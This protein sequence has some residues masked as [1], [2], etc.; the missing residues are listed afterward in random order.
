MKK[1]IYFVTLLFSS[2]TFAT[3]SPY[4]GEITAEDLLAQYPAFAKEYKNYSP[5]EDDLNTIKTLSGK[6]VLVFLGTWCHDSKR[7][8]PRLLKLLDGSG[9]KLGSLQLIAVGYDKL[10]PDGLAKQYDLRYTPTFIVSSNG[11]ELL[12]MIEK[13]KHSIAMDLT[14]L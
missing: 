9:V 5:S 8:V 2:F 10:D 14:R 12:R 6:Q 7:E 4:S 1:V 3:T 13:P 11:K